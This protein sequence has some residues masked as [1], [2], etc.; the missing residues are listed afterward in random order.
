M[1]VND[2]EHQN[3]L[4]ASLS[5][6]YVVAVPVLDFGQKR[7]TWKCMFENIAVFECV[8]WRYSFM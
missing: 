1:L 7:V 3:G 2:F 6:N 8:I 5:S 4:L